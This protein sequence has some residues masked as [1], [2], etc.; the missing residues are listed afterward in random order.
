MKSIIEEGAT[1]LFVSHSK[2]KVK[3]FCD[4]AILLEKGMLIDEGDT[5]Y[6]LDQYEEL[7]KKVRAQR[8]AKRVL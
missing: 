4:R 5:D 6:I 7:M 3:E 2:D 1:V 8:Q